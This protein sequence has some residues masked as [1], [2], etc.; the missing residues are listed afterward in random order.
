MMM[1]MMMMMA[2]ALIWTIAFNQELTSLYVDV[3]EP[4]M[5]L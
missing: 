2:A 5:V 1:M 4:L 3:I